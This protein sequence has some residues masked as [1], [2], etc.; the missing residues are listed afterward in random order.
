MADSATVRT[1]G[2]DQHG[3]RPLDELAREITAG[4]VR[5]ASA[6]AAWLRLV[7]EF[8]RRKGWAQWGVKSCSHWLSW[9]CS[10]APGAAREYVRVASAL[11]ALPLLDEAFAAG[12]LSYSKVRAVT[13]VTDRVR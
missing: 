9:A 5:L 10:V 8:D 3:Q 13:R 2:G 4:A 12:R 6:T 7:A 1:I 11:T